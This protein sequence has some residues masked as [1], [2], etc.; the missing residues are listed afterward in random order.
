MTARRCVMCGPR[1]ARAVPDLGPLLF[2]SAAK[3][4]EYT[5]RNGSCQPHPAARMKP[6]SARQPGIPLGGSGRNVGGNGLGQMD[7]DHSLALFVQVDGVE[8][9]IGARLERLPA[10]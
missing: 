1:P 5:K 6:R 3:W 7:T 2:R 4:P 10:P 8:E 9:K